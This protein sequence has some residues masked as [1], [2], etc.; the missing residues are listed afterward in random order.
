MFS[1]FVGILRSQARIL[2]TPFKLFRIHILLGIDFLFDR[3]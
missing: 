2:Y 3:L 1:G